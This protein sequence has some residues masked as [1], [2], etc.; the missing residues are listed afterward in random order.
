MTGLRSA[1]NL[2][3]LGSISGEF[4]RRTSLEVLMCSVGLR[5]GSGVSGSM[6]WMNADLPRVKA[7]PRRIHD[8]LYRELGSIGLA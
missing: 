5:G 2:W 7:S 6:G 4:S 3:R 8:C 1:T